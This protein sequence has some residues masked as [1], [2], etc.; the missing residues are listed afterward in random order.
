[1]THHYILQVPDVEVDW[2]CALDALTE[3]G[4]ADAYNR[5]H[6]GTVVGVEFLQDQLPHGAQAL[7]MTRYEAGSPVEAFNGFI[8]KAWD[9][10]R[11]RLDEIVAAC[12]EL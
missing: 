4:V 3:E 8:V 12:E 9:L 6:N 10:S 7:V 11:E 5:E 2:D 1:M